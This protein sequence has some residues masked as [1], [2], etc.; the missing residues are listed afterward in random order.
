I[1]PPKPPG[2]TFDMDPEVYTVPEPVMKRV[3]SIA[4]EIKGTEG[5]RIRCLLAIAE[6][7]GD[8]LDER[9]WYYSSQPTL[10]YTAWHVKDSQRRWMT[11]ATQGMLPFDGFAGANYGNWRTYPVRQLKID[12]IGGCSD[13]DLRHKLE[14][15][16]EDYRKSV[17]YVSRVD[18]S[19][20]QGGG[21][22]NS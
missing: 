9:L 7:V 1:P 10:R 15:I 11:E 14:L 8:P 3:K 22:S 6:R 20:T 16:E 12:C 4:K 17:F 19:A 5:E 13:A 18:A 2:K 21:S